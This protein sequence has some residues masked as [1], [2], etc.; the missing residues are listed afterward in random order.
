M[1]ILCAVSNLADLSTDILENDNNHPISKIHNHLCLCNLLLS[2]DAVYHNKVIEKGGE[3]CAT[4]CF[5]VCC[6][7][8]RKNSCTAC[9]DLHSAKNE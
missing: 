2:R 8:S 4:E 6:D 5:Y 7:E 1:L 9:Q 3:S